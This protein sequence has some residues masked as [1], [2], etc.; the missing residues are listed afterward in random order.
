MLLMVNIMK[1][2]NRRIIICELVVIEDSQFFHVC[3]LSET[4]NHYFI[5]V[6]EFE[7]SRPERWYNKYRCGDGLA[8]YLLK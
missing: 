1:G 6:D 3:Y 5:P 4:M 7:V 8:A 2:P